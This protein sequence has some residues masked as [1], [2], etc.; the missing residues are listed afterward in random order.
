M[1]KFRNTVMMFALILAV[2]LS[3][4]CGGG[5][6]T[7]PSDPGGK[8]YYE[9]SGQRVVCPENTNYWGYDVLCRVGSVTNR[10]NVVTPEGAKVWVEDGANV[11]PED[12]AA[13][14]LGLQRAF[15]KATC[16]GYN[17]TLAKTHEAYIVVVLK[18]TDRD[19]QGNPAYRWPCSQYCGT[20]WDKGGYV[21]VAGQMAAVGNPYGNIIMIPDPAPDKLDYAASGTEYEAEHVILAHY[22]GDLFNASKTHGAGYGHPIWSC[23]SALRTLK[24]KM[25]VVPQNPDKKGIMELVE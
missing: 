3:F 8:V 2:S 11:T 4:G 1:I 14:D 20:Q 6:P 18:A 9:V 7:D 15:D 22:D 23:T 16:Q 5:V 12:L 25:G 17:G 21:L 24:P 13:I 19:S 10:N